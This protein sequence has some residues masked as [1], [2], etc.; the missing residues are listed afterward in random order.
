MA[1][2]AYISPR[3]DG[4]ILHI[5][6]QPRAS[7]TEFGEVLDDRLKLRVACPPV[8]GKANKEIVRCLAKTFGLAKSRVVILRGE[9]SRQKDIL[10]R[11][12][13]PDQV[14]VRLKLPRNVPN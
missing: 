5:N 2:P 3:N 12:I 10:L 11:D 8:D 13:D 1:F 4:T 7:K 6:A 14:Q 9:T